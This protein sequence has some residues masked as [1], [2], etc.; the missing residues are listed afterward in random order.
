MSDFEELRLWA[1]AQIDNSA[2]PE[3]RPDI[4]VTVLQLLDYLT[5]LQEGATMDGSATEK[6]GSPVLDPELLEKMLRLHSQK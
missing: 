3:V 1:Q 5:E 6:P 4:G 2:K